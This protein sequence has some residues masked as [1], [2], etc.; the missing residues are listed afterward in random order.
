MQ[1]SRLGPISPWNP[2]ENIMNQ[3]SGGIQPIERPFGVRGVEPSGRTRLLDK[4]PDQARGMCGGKCEVR[5][6]CSC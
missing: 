3:Q 4:S 5:H 2:D 1:T 6:L